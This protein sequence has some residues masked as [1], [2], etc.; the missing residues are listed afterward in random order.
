MKLEPDMKIGKWTLVRPV[1][2]KRWLCICDCGTTRNV[3]AEK[4][5]GGATKSCGCTRAGHHQK[6]MGTTLK[7]GLHGIR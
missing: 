4:L 5:S 3:L 1:E 7:G 6:A 2:D